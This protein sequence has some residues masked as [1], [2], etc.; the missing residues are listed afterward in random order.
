[1][2]RMTHSTST[3][4]PSPFNYTS[5]S[6]SSSGGDASIG[7]LYS[8][9]FYDIY[10]IVYIIIC[11]V[12]L[13]LSLLQLSTHNRRSRHTP[14]SLQ[15]R[16][17]SIGVISSNARHAVPPIKRIFHWFDFTYLLPFWRYVSSKMMVLWHDR[18][19][20]GMTLMLSVLIP[21][22]LYVWH[23]IPLWL[24][25][26]AVNQIIFL[27]GFPSISWYVLSLKLLYRY[28]SQT[29]PSWYT[30]Y[31]PLILFITSTHAIAKVMSF[32]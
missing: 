22:P 28:S 15:N 9:Q 30:V 4:I 12:T 7:P 25:I 18:S 5:S 29:I 16:V 20:L 13:L 24:N 1:M 31:P 11:G 10:Q 14:T 2:W 23:T 27:I 17:E 21:D 8:A 3:A 26:L 32:Y 6:S 19:V